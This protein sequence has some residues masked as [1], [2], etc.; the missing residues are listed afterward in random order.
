[1]TSLNVLDSVIQ[2][3]QPSEFARKYLA[4]SPDPAQT[5]IL[6]AHTPIVILCCTR[7]WGKSTTTAARAVYQAFTYPESLILIAAPTAR[8]S[9]ELVR[10][11][12]AF[13]LRLN[14]RRRRDPDH[15]ISLVLPNESRIIGLPNAEDNI[16]GF[17]AP[18]LILI[19]E[20]SR[21]PDALYHGSLLP[22]LAAAP[23]SA[24][25]W[26][27]STPNGR[28]GFFYAEYTA[29]AASPQTSPTQVTRITVTAPECPRISPKALAHQAARMPRHFYEQEF[30]CA[31]HSP[32]GAL[33]SPDD[34]D[35]CL[36]LDTTPLL[37][38]P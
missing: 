37:V 14:I 15:S 32:T 11:C 29:A 1:M 21:V 12:A 6:D 2:A 30:L 10:K 28:Q 36:D 23:D 13:L 20:A 5:L 24:S 18:S 22:M 8:Q 26:M 16:R 7:Q 9:S 4:F 35:A 34:L 3:T 31:F 19:D 38:H 27:L 17:S 33:L 25:L